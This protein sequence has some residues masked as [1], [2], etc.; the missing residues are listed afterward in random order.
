MVN[1]L[2][3]LNLSGFT[4]FLSTYNCLCWIWII[5]FHYTAS[6]LQW[7]QSHCTSVCMQCLCDWVNIYIYIQPHHNHLSKSAASSCFALCI[8]VSSL[9]VYNHLY[10]IASCILPLVSQKLGNTSCHP[11][12]EPNKSPTSY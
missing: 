7:F 11:K 12:N 3:E 4:Y 1:V 9:A 10:I 8:N 2:I 6:N 5:P